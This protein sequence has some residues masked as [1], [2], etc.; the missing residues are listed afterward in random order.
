MSKRDAFHA[1]IEYTFI[2]NID[3]D[4]KKQVQSSESHLKLYSQAVRNTEYLIL[5]AQNA[6]HSEAWRS[7]DPGLLESLEL[8]GQVETEWGKPMD[9]STWSHEEELQYCAAC[10]KC[11]CVL[12]CFFIVVCI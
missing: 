5:N 6:V 9:V 3:E 10:G 4:Y 11:K 7:C 2:C 1:Y 8:L 12:E